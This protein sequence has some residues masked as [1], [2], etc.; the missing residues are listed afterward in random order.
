MHLE[1]VFT[2]CLRTRALLLQVH[3]Y[4]IYSLSAFVTIFLRA[5]DVVS[6]DANPMKEELEE[7]AKGGEGA[8]A[9]GDDEDGEG[10]EEDEVR[11]LLLFLWFCV[12]C[13]V[14]WAARRLH[15]CGSE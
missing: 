14:V 9:D 13:V 8:D 2:A 7:A 10:K 12:V 11:S 6:G 1:G 15:G 4:Y 3:T 5:I